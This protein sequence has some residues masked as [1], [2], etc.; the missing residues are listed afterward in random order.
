MKITAKLAMPVVFINLCLVIDKFSERIP[1]TVARL[2][3]ASM[4]ED[5]SAHNERKSK[6]TSYI[7]LFPFTGSSLAV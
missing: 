3:L 1:L 2:I 5:N 6:I 4:M 7:H